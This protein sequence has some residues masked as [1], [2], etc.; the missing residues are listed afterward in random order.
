MVQII[1]ERCFLLPPP[2][3]CAPTRR[4]RRTERQLEELVIV[5]LS[6]ARPLRVEALEALGERLDDDAGSYEA[7]E[8]DSTVGAAEGA[9]GRGCRGGRR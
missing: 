6:P 1:E 3:P 9:C 8:G 2:P 5:D 7:V 4:S